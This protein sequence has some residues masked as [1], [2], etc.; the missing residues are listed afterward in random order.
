MC[1]FSAMNGSNNKSGILP[2]FPVRAIVRLHLF[3]QRSTKKGRCHRLS[4]ARVSSKAKVFDGSIPDTSTSPSDERAKHV[5][6]LATY[7]LKV[8]ADYTPCICDVKKPRYFGLF[9]KFLCD[10]SCSQ[11]T[12]RAGRL[13]ATCRAP[14]RRSIF[15]QWLL[16]SIGIMP[17]VVYTT[18]ELYDTAYMSEGTITFL[19]LSLYVAHSIW[20]AVYTYFLVCAACS[21]THRISFALIGYAFAV[22]LHSTYLLLCVYSRV[23]KSRLSLRILDCQGKKLVYNLQCL[24]QKVRVFPK[25]PCKFDSP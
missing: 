6:N 24:F 8:L 4:A 15:L 18:L 7:L 2:L 14:F 22:T 16:T 1:G 21:Q 20:T 23:R 3:T 19:F 11:G 12:R 5:R 9:D 17:G 10:S 25:T 13:R